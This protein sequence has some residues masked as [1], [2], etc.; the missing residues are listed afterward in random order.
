[1]ENESRKTAQTASENIFVPTELGSARWV[2]L[3]KDNESRHDESLDNQADLAP[4]GP[5]WGLEPS[6]N[7]ACEQA[8]IDYESF[9]RGLRLDVS[10]ED[11]AAEFE[12]EETTVKNLKERFYHM[13]AING[14]S[15][16]TG[17]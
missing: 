11:M 1:M 17:M 5:P 14:N 13:E 2:A 16:I 3:N 9:V 10:D 12:V 4:I 6:M 15:G 8:G 7:S